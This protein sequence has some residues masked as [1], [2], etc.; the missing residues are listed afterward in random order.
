MET[1]KLKK[2]IDDGENTEVELKQ[3]FQSVQ[4]VARIISAF[5]NTQGGLLILGVGDDGAILGLKDDL[6]KLQQKVSQASRIIHPAPILSVETHTVDGKKLLVVAAHKADSSVFHSV[7]GVIYVRIGSTIQKLEG[8]SIVEFLRNRQ[9]LLFEESIDPAAK[10]DDIDETKVR[11]YLEKRGQPGYLNDHSLSDF[12]LS[13]K[14][15]SLQPDLKIKNSALL[16]FTKDTQAF[17][18]QT[19]IK[20][21]RFGGKEPMNV[22]AYEDAKGNIPQTIEHTANFVMRF[23]PKSFLI[24]GMQRKDIPA[25]PERAVREAIINAVAHRDYFNKNETQVSVFDDR[26]EITNPGGL[27]EGMTE[28]LLGALSIQRN[29]VVYQMLKDYGHMEGIGSGITKMRGLM[30]E[31]G[32]SEPEFAISKEFFRIDRKSVV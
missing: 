13:K 32:L 4:D 7:E 5:A 23:V 10:L 30:K 8:Q 11:A 17:L 16:F 26:L 31:A 1:E 15:A 2:I 21:V 12:L 6:D 27:P 18:P 24:E 28:Q 29:P 25:L 22:I 19:Q 3:S 14:I 9:I 20:L